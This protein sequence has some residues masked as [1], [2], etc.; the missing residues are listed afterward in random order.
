MKTGKSK[1]TKR[2]FLI[3]PLVFGGALM[4]AAVAPCLLNNWRS[5]PGT[6][7][8]GSGVQCRT[9]TGQ[10]WFPTYVKFSNAGW[11][12][13]PSSVYTCTYTCKN[14]MTGKTYNWA[15]PGGVKIMY[16]TF[17]YGATNNGTGGGS[18]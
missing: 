15:G 8:L 17:C 1:R 3:P 7:T 12:G 18:G 2:K 16:S 14:H 5:C 9:P 13:A 4:A 11:S 10:Y 6:I